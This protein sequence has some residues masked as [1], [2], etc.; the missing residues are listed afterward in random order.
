MLF[1][2]VKMALKDEGWG[3]YIG[4]REGLGGVVR[5]D[6]EGVKK[7]PRRRRFCTFKTSRILP[8]VGL[9]EKP[10]STWALLSFLWLESNYITTLRP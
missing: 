9:F 8:P 10:F 5:N 2:I 4:E 1:R 7:S 6:V 3:V